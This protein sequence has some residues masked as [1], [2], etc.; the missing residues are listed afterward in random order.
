MSG[1]KPKTDLGVKQFDW[2]VV[3]NRPKIKTYLNPLVRA[4]TTCRGTVMTPEQINTT[5]SGG[6][7]TKNNNTIEDARIIIKCLLS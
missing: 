1:I 2:M 3:E 4:S 5:N 6:R 7:R